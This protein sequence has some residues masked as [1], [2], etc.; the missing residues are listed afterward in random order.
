[1]EEHASLQCLDSLIAQGRISVADNILELGNSRNS[2]V[3]ICNVHV[4]EGGSS[5]LDDYLLLALAVV[6]VE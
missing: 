4:T 5:F 3:Q 6:V 1:V 2:D